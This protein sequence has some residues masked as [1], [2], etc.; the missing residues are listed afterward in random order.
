[1]KITV[2]VTE[3]FKARIKAGIK[4]CEEHPS[5]YQQ[6]TQHDAAVLTNLDIAMNLASEVELAGSDLYVIGMVDDL[7]AKAAEPNDI[8]DPIDETIMVEIGRAHV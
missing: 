6:P 8:L 2:Q 5:G 4:Y 1:M 3:E 7:I